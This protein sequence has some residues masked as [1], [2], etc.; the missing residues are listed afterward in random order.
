MPSRVEVDDEAAIGGG[1]VLVAGGPRGE[2]LRL[3][4]GEV[5][6][7]Q[8][9]VELLRVGAPGAAPD[10]RMVTQSSSS[11]SCCTS[12]PRMPA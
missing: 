1:L 7:P 11:S 2:H 6:H 12:Q 9:E 10:G 3:T 5:G 4:V 8:V